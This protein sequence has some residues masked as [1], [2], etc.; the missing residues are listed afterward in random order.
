[1]LESDTADVNHLA[2]LCEN[3]E[4]RSLRK[5]TVLWQTNISIE[6]PW[7]N[8][9]DA[10]HVE[11]TQQVSLVKVAKWLCQRNCANVFMIN[12][13]LESTSAC[14]L[15]TLT[16]EVIIRP[17]AGRLVLQRCCSLPRQFLIW[18][19]LPH[20]TSSKWKIFFVFFSV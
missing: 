9:G 12:L 1:M 2:V 7:V 10:V 18:L 5:H 11:H 15:M 8:T 19:S 3:E 16:P 6:L 20:F 4:W 14:F 13:K 17:T